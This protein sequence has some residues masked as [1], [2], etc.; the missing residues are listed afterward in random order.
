MSSD[1]DILLALDREA[2]RSNER[3]RAMLMEMGRPDLVKE[4]DARLRDIR[5]GLDSA[6]SCWHS[7]SPAQRRVLKIMEPGRY[8]ARSRG[9]RTR[10]NAYGEPHAES[11]VCGLA[12][13]RALCAHEL[14]HVDGGATDPERKFVLTERGRFV[15]KHGQSLPEAPG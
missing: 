9:S 13:L 7:I 14:C 5:L 12:T 10:Y 15:L 4:L 3:V 11:N 6:R 1:D 2:R 8:L